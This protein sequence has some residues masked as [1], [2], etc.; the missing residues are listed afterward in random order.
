MDLIRG[1][2]KERLDLRDPG[3]IDDHVK[4]AEFSFCVIDSSIHVIALGDVGFEGRCFAPE[5]FHVLSDACHLCVVE[6]HD[7]NVG[8]LSCKTQCDGATN[9]LTGARD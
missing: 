8:S 5:V 3:V 6:V 4:P 1:D 7:R 2:F 9:S